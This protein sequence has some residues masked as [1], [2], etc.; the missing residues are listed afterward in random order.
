MVKKHLQ[1]API[2]A[3]IRRW[4]CAGASSAEALLDWEVKPRGRSYRTYQHDDMK[5]CAESY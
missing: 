5:A 3:G 2:Y 1:L 4:P